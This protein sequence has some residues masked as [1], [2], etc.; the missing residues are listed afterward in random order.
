M[1]GQYI[2]LGGWKKI[3][4]VESADVAQLT[5]NATATGATDT[6]V[7]TMNELFIEGAVS[8][9]R[10]ELDYIPRIR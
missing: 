2:Y 9:T 8:L 10:F 3:H 4:R 1:A 5:V 7:I 6:P